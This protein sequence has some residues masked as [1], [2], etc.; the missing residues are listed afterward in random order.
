MTDTAHEA[1]EAAESDTGDAGKRQAAE[2]I[3]WLNATLQELRG[4]L[5]ACGACI[6]AGT[7]APEAV[8]APMNALV[9]EM[10]GG[11]PPAAGAAS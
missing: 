5:T 8:S 11:A 10:M 6:E 1:P 9:L 4:A 7:L 3:A 2:A